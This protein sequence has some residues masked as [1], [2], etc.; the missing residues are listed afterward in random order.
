VIDPTGK[1]T[2]RHAGTLL[3]IG[4]GRDHA[5]TPVLLLVHDLHVRIVNAATGELLPELTL[6]PTNR[7]QGTGKP[8]GRT[9]R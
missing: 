4:I 3:K 8:H 6:D 5:R 9:N 7:Y 2:L 1:V